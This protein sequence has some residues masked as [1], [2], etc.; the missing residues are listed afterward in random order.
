MTTTLNTQAQIQKKTYR[1]RKSPH[2][3]HD[4]KKYKLIY[5]A[6]R[7]LKD[8]ASS[9][10][11]V[12]FKKQYKSIIG[13][14]RAVE[15]TIICFKMFCQKQDLGPYSYLFQSWSNYLG[16]GFPG[17]ASN[18]THYEISNKTDPGSALLQRCLINAGLAQQ[19]ER[20]ASIY[21]SKHIK[22]LRLNRCPHLPF[23]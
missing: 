21:A 16:P 18:F 8:P 9:S 14:L 17:P 22:G 19:S 4:S 5:F 20:Q 11:S 23:C 7:I 15:K 2:N 3:N 1:G 12:A 10:L 6:V 13:N